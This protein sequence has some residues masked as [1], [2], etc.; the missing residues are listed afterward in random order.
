[1]FRGV[2]RGIRTLFGKGSRRDGLFS[3]N[4]EK[5]FPGM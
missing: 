1:L 3:F 5:R 4:R 2:E